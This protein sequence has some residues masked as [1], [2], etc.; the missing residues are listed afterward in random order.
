[1]DLRLQSMPGIII[2]CRMSRNYTMSEPAVAARK[3]GAAA[4]WHQ[5]TAR[6]WRSLKLEAELIARIDMQRGYMS[7]N[8]YLMGVVPAKA[9]GQRKHPVST[10][11]K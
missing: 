2:F 4:R 7:R 8:D 5:H 9:P 6:E 10:P 1:M 11:T 3:K